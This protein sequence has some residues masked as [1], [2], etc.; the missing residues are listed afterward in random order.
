MKCSRPARSLLGLVA[1]SA[2]VGI[3][4]APAASALG[5]V[6]CGAV[7]TE[8]VKLTA[9]LDCSGDTPAPGA[10]ILTVGAD[11]I[12]IDL[13]GYSIIDGDDEYH[14]LINVDGRHNVRVEN[15]SLVGGQH[16]GLRIHD[17]HQVTVHRLHVSDVATSVGDP[18]DTAGISVEGSRK[19]HLHRV[20]VTGNAD[21]GMYVAGSQDVHVHHANS[22][23]NDDDGLDAEAVARMDVKH[24]TFSNNDGDGLEADDSPNLH[25]DGVVADDNDGDGIDLDTVNNARVHKVSVDGSGDDGLEINDSANVRVHHSEFSNSDDDGIDVDSS[26]LHID[27]VAVHGNNDD[28]LYIEDSAGFRVKHLI[29]TSNGEDGVDIDGNNG[30]LSEYRIEHSASNNNADAG[31]EID[32]P[33]IGKKNSASGNGNSN[34]AP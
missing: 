4:V 34:S 2:G 30:D 9:D 25:L 23:N 14:S 32:H 10:A 28:G 33:V 16:S 11:R 29:A 24:S 7:I 13:N 26:T 17:A 1:A 20:T 31:F 21:D 5:S 6:T 22:S 19:V 3:V 15:G 18:D 8:N 27:R 12:K